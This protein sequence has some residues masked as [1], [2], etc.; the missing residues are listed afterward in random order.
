M[1]TTIHTPEPVDPDAVLAKYVRTASRAYR[2]RLETAYADPGAAYAGFR[3]MANARGLGEAAIQMR[4]TPASFGT[5]LDGGAEQAQEAAR[6]G[7]RAYHARLAQTNATLAASVLDEAFSE[8]LGQTAGAAAVPRLRAAWD[9]L[10]AAYGPERAAAV[11][12]RRAGDFTGGDAAPEAVDRF[13]EIA[14]ARDTL[15]ERLGIGPRYDFDRPAPLPRSLD[16]ERAAPERLPERQQA[17]IVAVTHAMQARLATGYQYPLIAEARLHSLINQ[18]GLAAIETAERDPT[19]LGELR[20][21]RPGDSVDSVAFARA[22]IAYARVAYQ[23]H[24]A[25]FPDRAAEL[26]AREALESVARS[27][28]DPQRAMEGVQEAI[29]LHGAALEEHL[30]QRRPERARGRGTD[31]GGPGGGG[32]EL[33]D[34]DEPR[35]PERVRLADDPAVDEAVR[36]YIA[37]EEAQVESQRGQDLRK[38]RASAETALARLDQQDEAVSRTMLDF[39][40]AAERA[41]TDPLKAATAWEKLV[42]D[43]KGNL[44]AARSKVAE[45]PAILGKVRSEPFPRWWG[46][47]AALV[48]VANEQPARDA[49]PRVLDRA[50]AHTKAQREA[51]NPMSWTTP[52]GETV[53]GR[54][55]VREAAGRVVSGRTTEIKAA[56]A[57]VREVGGVSRAEETAQRRFD[58]LSPDQRAQAGSKLAAKGRRGAGGAALP[59]GVLGKSM[60]AARVAREVGE[61]PASL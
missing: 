37:A 34:G 55:K 35:A 56:D 16:D 50:V 13:V 22:G 32:I 7:A 39:R 48:G 57:R 51:I 18:Q 61:G 21:D 8:A 28:R 12:R 26:E 60:R 6:L 2:D 52:E 20:V 3:D 17:R 36:A 10:S 54:E 46:K 41:Y 43:E 11:V 33:P 38:E 58:A 25:R 45:N 30:E 49:V 59:M 1:S 40:T 42:Q 23:Y 14:C 53:H 5:L 44:D 47:G 15:R 9:E 27:A 31:R 29:Q 19:V 4:E 24:T